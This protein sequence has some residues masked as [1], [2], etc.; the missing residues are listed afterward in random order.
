MK[1]VERRIF[2]IHPGKM[3]QVKGLEDRFW[4]LE[5][6]F[7]FP[8]KRRYECL[9]GPHDSETYSFERDWDS[10]AAAEAAI[11]KAYADPQL[12]ALLEEG[13]AVF[14]SSHAEFYTLLD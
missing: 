3:D 8:S 6:Q 11:Q 4:A 2:K 9:A 10:F 14:G 13:N 5:R 1:V 12:Q 7:G